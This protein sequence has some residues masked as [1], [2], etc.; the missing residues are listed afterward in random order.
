MSALDS[1]F[2]KLRISRNNL[3]TW[4]NASP[5]VASEWTDWRAVGGKWHSDNDVDDIKDVSEKQLQEIIARCD[6][7]LRAF[8]TNRVAIRKF[9][10]RAEEPFLKHAAYDDETREFVAGTLT[11]AEDLLEHIIFLTVARG[12]TKFLGL[13]TGLAVIH[14]YVF[15]PDIEEAIAMRLHP[16]AVSFADSTQSRRVAVETFQALVTKMLEPWQ[17]MTDG[18]NVQ[19]PAPIDE[20]DQLK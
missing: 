8:A 15:F 19:L 16:H 18:Q 13:R 3:I 6:A 11:Y 1:A 17:K 4:L 14:N 10:D 20:L 7:R 12:A 5:P 9:L 2:F